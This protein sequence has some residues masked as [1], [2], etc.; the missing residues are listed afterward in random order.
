MDLNKAFLKE[1]LRGAL[2]ILLLSIMKDSSGVRE[3][4]E[5]AAV[6][7]ATALKTLTTIASAIAKDAAVM[8]AIAKF[9]PETVKKE[10][11]ESV[12]ALILTPPSPPPSGSDSSSKECLNDRKDKPAMTRV[13]D[14]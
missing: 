14:A 1:A 13:I 2:N 9:A 11:A 8:T 5:E 6:R 3:S 4:F 10:V 12:N 7:V